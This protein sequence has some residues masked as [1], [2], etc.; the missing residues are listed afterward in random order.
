MR[1]KIGR[2]SA[3]NLSGVARLLSALVFCAV[4]VG[5]TSISAAPAGVVSG[6]LKKWHR[7]MITWE[8]PQTSE[9]N[10][11]NPFRNYR[12]SVLFSHAVTGKSYVVPGYFAADGDAANTS[13]DAGSRWRANFAPDETGT[14]N[15][16]ASFRAGEDVALSAS[17]DAGASSDFDGSSGDFVIGPTDKSGRDLRSKG[18]LQYV[19][20]HHLRFAETGEYFLK[21]GA[22]SPEN[23]LDYEDFDHQPN[24]GGARKSWSPHA[25]DFDAADAGEYTWAGGKGTEL[26]GSIRYLSEKGLN[27]FSFIPFTLDGDD[28]A[29]FP[30]RL[31]STP[32]S[33]VAAIHP[34][35]TKNVVHRDRFDVSKLEQWDRIFA[36]GDKKGMYLHFKT[37]EAEN[38]ATMDGGDLGPERTLYYRELIARFGYHLALNWNLGEEIV[39]ATTAQKRAWAQYFHDT[40]PYHHPIVIHNEIDPHYDLLGTNS[41]LTGF[42][43]QT[44]PAAIFSDTLDYLQRSDAAGVPWVVAFDE[45]NPWYDGII[46]DAEELHHDSVRGLA[47]WSHLLAGGAGCEFYFGANHPEN[48][49]N[50]QNMRSRDNWWNQCRYALEFFAINRVPFWNMTNQNSLLTGLSGTYCFGLSGKVYVGYLP[51]N[52][53]STLNLSGHPG[54]FTVRWFDPRAGGALQTGSVPEVTGGAPA[55]LGNPPPTS[56]H[57]WVVLVKLSDTSAPVVSITAPADGASLPA[58]IPVRITSGITDDVRVATAELWVD[59]ILRPPART[60][61]PYDFQVTGLGLGNHV[62][63]VVGED[64]NGNRGT[65]TVGIMLH[66]PAPPQLS[67]AADGG[68]L[69]LEWEVDGFELYRAEQM[70]GVWTRIVPVPSSPFLIAPSNGSEFFELRWTSP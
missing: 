51:T 54:Q 4:L 38:E 19:G 52:S 26:L 21:M 13:A 32:E 11:N 29:V 30:H 69:R 18:R 53:A 46:P 45:Q 56:T 64:S 66:E 36:Y 16:V 20:K 67:I 23:R 14:W 41:H 1:S 22:D 44:H 61:A 3:R 31:V 24:V 48:D 50:C 49:L 70:P 43:R 40:D 34:R 47:I 17:P 59:G 63:S 10:A 9:T 62:I 55:N 57:D 6:E 68:Q 2:T 65:N 39:V 15:Y 35:W 8:G 60:D 42:S 28:R 58:N 37:L 25:A 5:R 33:Y 12:L 7:V 27:A